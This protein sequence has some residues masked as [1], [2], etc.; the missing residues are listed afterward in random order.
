MYCA[1][2]N[3]CVYGYVGRGNFKPGC[4]LDD[5]AVAVAVV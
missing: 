4:F 2:M 5:I 3:V 1:V